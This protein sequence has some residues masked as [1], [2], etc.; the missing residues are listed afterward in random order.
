MKS[1]R[2]YFTTNQQRMKKETNILVFGDSNSG[3]IDIVK[4]ADI[5]SGRYYRYSFRKDDKYIIS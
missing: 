3:P 5:L 1:G 2:L 4:F